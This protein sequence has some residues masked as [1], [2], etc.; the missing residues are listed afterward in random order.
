MLDKQHDSAQSTEVGAIKVKLGLNQ[1]YLPSTQFRLGMGYTIGYDVAADLN[2]VQ[3][4]TTF[5]T[6]L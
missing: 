2:I 4:P 5:F 3:W 6:Q 1:L